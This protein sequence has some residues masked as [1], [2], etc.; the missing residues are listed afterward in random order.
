VSRA[1]GL[2]CAHDC[3]HRLQQWSCVSSNTVRSADSL[4]N[5]RRI[6]ISTMPLAAHPHNVR[7]SISHHHHPSPLPNS[8]RTRTPYYLHHDTP[9]PPPKTPLL[10]IHI[11]PLHPQPGIHTH[12]PPPHAERQRSLPNASQALARLRGGLE[13]TSSRRGRGEIGSV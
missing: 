8:A 2:H 1:Q 7:R 12:T 4:P 13:H 11:P 10:H 3:V 5:T 9:L 6:H